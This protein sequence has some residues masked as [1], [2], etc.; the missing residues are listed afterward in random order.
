L[1]GKNIGYYIGSFDPLHLGHQEVAREALK[2]GFCDYVLIV[3]AWGGDSY[4][5]RVDVSYRLKMIAAAFKNHPRILTTAL[6]PQDSQKIL[7]CDSET[8]VMGKPAVRPSLA[9]TKFIGIIGSDV[10]LEMG[11]S[12]KESDQEHERQKKAKAFMRGIKIP[13]THSKDTIGGIIALPVESFLVALRK[14]D[15]LTPLKGA[16]GERPILAILYNSLYPGLS[17]TKVKEYLHE[18]RN[19]QA[20]VSGE[21]LKIIKEG[22]LYK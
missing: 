22:N 11:L 1:Q 19:I 20:M 6:S 14:G 9:Q 10:A 2:S 4:K 21:V 3:P 13:K 5:K 17:S 15:D 16:I 18:G 7:T 12:R 8:L